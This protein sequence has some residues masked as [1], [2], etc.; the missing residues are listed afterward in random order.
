MVQLKERIL[1]Q[2]TNNHLGAEVAT[3]LQRMD[4]DAIV[5]G[6]EKRCF[7]IKDRENNDLIFVLT[8][9]TE[10]YVTEKDGVF[11]ISEILGAE[12][13]CI[14]IQLRS[15]TNHKR[16]LQLTATQIICRLG[17]RPNLKGYRYLRSAI[18][19]AA[20]KPE[21]L[22]GGFQSLYGTVAK[23]YET[24]IL[25]V[26]RAI[27]NAIDTAYAQNPEQMREMFYYPT[28]RPCCSEVVCLA[29][30]LIRMNFC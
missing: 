3:R 8:D 21:L 16:R 5:C 1:V 25:C 4:I 24:D 28:K 15:Y 19:F 27:R 14:I 6:G 29:V 10:D 12:S 22:E 30:D 17:I 13:I 2:T 11:Y 7:A 20:E 23:E 18:V 9:C 26:E